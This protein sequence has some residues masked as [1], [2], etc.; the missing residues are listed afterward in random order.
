MPTQL[1]TGSAPPTPRFGW[2][3]RDGFRPFF[4]GAAVCGVVHMAAWLMALSGHAVNTH[5]GLFGWH[6]HEMIVGYGGAALAGFLLTSVPSWT[7]GNTP[8]GMP[9]ALLFGLWLAGR[10]MVFLPG[11]FSPEVIAAVDMAFLPVLAWVLSKPLAAAGQHYNVVVPLLVSLAGANALMHASVLG[12]PPAADRAGN[13]LAVGVMMVGISYIG[14]R[15]IPWFTERVPGA[16]PRSFKTVEH[17]AV[18][19]VALYAATATLADLLALPDAVASVFALAAAVLNGVRLAGWLTLGAWRVPLVWVVHLGY[20]WL[21]LGLAMQAG[22]LW[23][24]LERTSAIHAFTVGAIGLMTMGLM[25][26]ASLGHSGRPV[27]AP[28]A[29]TIAFVMLALATPLRVAAP[30]LSWERASTALSLAGGLWCAAFLLFLIRYLPVL[31]GPPA[32]PNG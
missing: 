8:T 9:L 32:S 13:I 18:P 27:A 15:V 12:Q 19:A 22:A 14:G 1:G 16:V 30:Y 28:P 10:V 3:F 5:F 23:G 29:A 21:V 4:L 2:L 24:V 7:G 26:H 11:T 25:A 17:L 6:A 20:G 31:L